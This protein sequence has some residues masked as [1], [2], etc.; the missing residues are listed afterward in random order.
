M[1]HNIWRIVIG[2]SLIVSVL[3]AC[4]TETQQEADST[5]VSEYP[6]NNVEPPDGQT[7]VAQVTIEPVPTDSIVAPTSTLYVMNEPTPTPLANAQ[8]S[9]GSSELLEF[10]SFEEYRAELHACNAEVEW[11][12]GYAI[13]VEK[14]AFFDGNNSS[15]G[16]IGGARTVITLINACAWGSYWLD[17]TQMGDSEAADTAVQY[18][19]D[20]LLYFRLEGLPG[21]QA[22]DPLLQGPID[23]ARLGD[24][25]GFQQMLNSGECDVLDSTVE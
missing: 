6:A 15:G 5:T 24:P 25:S 18:M 12:P 7:D 21:P 23:K 1:R 16:Q 10:Q 19:S 2:C 4:G 17:S 14:L 11:P 13:N 3:V 8:C 22:A 20:G 9:Y